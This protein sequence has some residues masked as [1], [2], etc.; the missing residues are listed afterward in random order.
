MSEASDMLYNLHT[1]DSDGFGNTSISLL[2][3]FLRF[4]R[5]YIYRWWDGNC[6]QADILMDAGSHYFSRFWFWRWR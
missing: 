4:C 6:Q 2:N 1:A 3:I 5:E